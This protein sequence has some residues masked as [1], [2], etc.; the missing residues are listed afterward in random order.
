MS[1]LRTIHFHLTRNT[2]PGELTALEYK[3]LKRADKKKY[4]KTAISKGFKKVWEDL[5]TA[6]DIRSQKLNKQ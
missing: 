4:K 2:L 3:S 1:K 6:K 5:Y